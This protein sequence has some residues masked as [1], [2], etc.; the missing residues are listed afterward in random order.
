MRHQIQRAKNNNEQAAG[1]EISKINIH[2]EKREVIAYV[3]Q[4]QIK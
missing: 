2:R 4:I 3:K 1:F